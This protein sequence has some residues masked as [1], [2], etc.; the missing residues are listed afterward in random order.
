MIWLRISDVKELRALL[1]NELIDLLIPI[2]PNSQTASLLNQQSNPSLPLL[3]ILSILSLFFL[4][5][6]NYSSEYTY[7]LSVLYLFHY[8]TTEDSS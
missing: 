1:N 3:A 6:T 8:S 5:D 2:Y 7:Q 4:L